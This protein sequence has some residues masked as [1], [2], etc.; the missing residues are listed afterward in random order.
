MST[1]VSRARE[2]QIPEDVAS[3]LPVDLPGSAPPVPPP[4]ESPQQAFLAGDY[5]QTVCLVLLAVV[6]SGWALA[7]M[8]SVLTPL[9]VAL[10]LYFLL[11]PASEALTRW[12][13]PRVASGILFFVLVLA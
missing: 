6:A 4:T 3:D 12:R 8:H 10:F 7:A 11:L 1:A 5:I 9:L 2:A 13:V